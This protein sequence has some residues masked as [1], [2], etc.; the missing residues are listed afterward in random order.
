[1]P[2]FSRHTTSGAFTLTTYTRNMWNPMFSLI[3][4]SIKL[5]LK[6]KNVI[7]PESNPN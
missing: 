6:D 5:P 7:I 1:M 4:A 2:V 3:I